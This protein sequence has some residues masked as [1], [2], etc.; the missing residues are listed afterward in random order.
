MRHLLT[1]SQPL[2]TPSDQ[3]STLPTPQG[4]ATLQGWAQVQPGWQQ[5][6]EPQD[7]DELP[8]LPDEDLAVMARLMEQREAEEA[9]RPLPMA[10]YY[11]DEIYVA[12]LDAF[13]HQARCRCGRALQCRMTAS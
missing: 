9:A 10:E 2:P 11:D 5:L 7:S 3:I 4:L 8:V 13:D 1:N 6:Y 12:D